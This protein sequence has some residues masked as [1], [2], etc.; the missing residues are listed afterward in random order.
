MELLFKIS[1]ECHNLS[2]WGVYWWGGA[3]G[4]NMLSLGRVET[5]SWRGG[6]R[7]MERRGKGRGDDY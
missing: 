3:M 5:K 4:R 1:K 7:R 6:T 2:H